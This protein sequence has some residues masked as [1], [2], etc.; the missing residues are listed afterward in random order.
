M[1]IEEQRKILGTKLKSARLHAMAQRNL[2][3]SKR[4]RTQSIVAKRHQPMTQAFAAKRLGISQSF[5]SK[6]EDGRLEPNFPLVERMAAY[7]GINLSLF[8]TLSSEERTKLHHLND[9]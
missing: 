9:R 8:Q 6:L 3:R 7:Y 4:A 2:S 1:D 5:L